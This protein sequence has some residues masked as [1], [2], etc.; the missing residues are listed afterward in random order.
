VTP[1]AT[2]EK[3]VS[4]Y[5]I[6]VDGNEIEESLIHRIREVRVLNYLR[7]PDMCTFS[8]SFPKGK[9]GQGEPIDE[10]PFEIGRKLEIKLGARE[11]LTTSTLFKGEI[12]TL[13][14]HFGAGS[15]ELV[16]R[17]FDR[18]H[19]LQR[20][21]RSVAYTNMTASDIVSMILKKAGFD[22]QCDPSGD[23]YEHMYQHNETDWDFIWRLAEKIGFEFFVEDRTANF[24]APVADPP[25]ELEWPKTLRSFNPRVT[26]IQQVAEVTLLAW[27]PDT[28]KEIKV[29]VADPKQIAKIGIDRESIKKAFDGDTIQVATEPVHSEA[30]A[31]Q[32]A[33]ALLDKLA[34]GY[35][36]AEGVCDGDP[37]IKPGTAIQVKGL[38]QKFSGTY[39]VAAA[40]HVLR[41]G[42][43]YE[44]RFAN[45]PAHTLSGMV[46]AD[47][48][49]S[50]SSF[51]SQLVVGVVTNNKDPDDMGRV[52]VQYPAL[53]PDGEGAWARIA[54]PSAGKG[55][56][57]MML[58][59]VGEEVLIGFEHE[60]MTRPYV[61]GSVF[62]GKDKPGD[63]LLKSQ[64]GSFS[65]RS[66]KDIDLVSKGDMLLNSSGK[67]SIQVSG[68]IAAEG[69]SNVSVKGQKL[70]IKGDTEIS[71]EANTTLTLKCGPNQIQLSSSGVTVSGP[72]ISLG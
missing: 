37:K 72:M 24:R 21:R 35:I 14:P 25:V 19:I 44:T 48:G 22:A 2:A 4:L 8:A 16:V 13:E 54:G 59:V 64:N 65:L 34:N 26:A 61:L 60:D 5:S 9:E 68:E 55:R 67:L 12:L 11:D 63:D 31:R 41:G 7:L 45:S 10:H 57:L 20:S 36:A 70:S 43:T 18:S 51:G 52:K 30:E 47:R 50:V 1:A 53:D 29:T 3:H 32:L 40:T 69:Q 28:K 38:G 58:P 23:P 46:G 66:D 15:V 49:S 33:Q 27:D 62:N 17:G 6:L 39:R 42:A 71:I 56:G